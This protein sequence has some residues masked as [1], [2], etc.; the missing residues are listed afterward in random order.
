MSAL[1]WGQYL[2][3]FAG[4]LFDLRFCLAGFFCSALPFFQFYDSVENIPFE[5]FVKGPP[6]F[7][8]A[9]R[10]YLSLE[11]ASWACSSSARCVS[12]LS[13]CSSWLT[14]ASVSCRDAVALSSGRLPCSAAQASL[15]PSTPP[16]SWEQMTPRTPLLIRTERETRGD[17]D[18]PKP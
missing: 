1:M 6:M 8:R 2:I 13:D 9:A 4:L 18:V 5:V 11:D 15:R 10:V 14:V 16:P 7:R 12:F 17:E 3:L